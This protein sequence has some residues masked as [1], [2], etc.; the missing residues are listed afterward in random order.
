MLNINRLIIDA[1]VTKLRSV[2]LEIYGD[3]EPLYAHTLQ[4]SARQ[5]LE[6]IARTDTLYHNI[7]HT[8]MAA[9]AGSAILKGKEIQDGSITPREWLHFMLALLF[10]DIGFVRGLC[11]GD[12]GDKFATGIKDETV[13]W[14][15]GKSAAILTP[16]HVDRS[17]LFLRERFERS[18][19]LDLDINVV[20]D[21]IERTRFPVPDKNPYISTDDLPGLVRAADLIGQLADPN[22]LQKIPALF[23]EFEE[24]GMNKNL[25][26]HDPGEMRRNYPSFFSSAVEP[27][28]HDALPFLRITQEGQQW[29]T[30]LYGNVL[31]AKQGNYQDPA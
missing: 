19:I 24:S 30:S 22:Y 5:A 4:F 9:L 3:G 12:Q 7:E 15:D 20:A 10:H 28:I 16:Y 21:Y 2:F 6:Q 1:F 8:I 26:Y 18:G 29:I 11:R 25:G 14:R 17:K 27:Y 23:Y 13:A 31:V